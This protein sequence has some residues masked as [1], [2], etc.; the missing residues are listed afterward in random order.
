MG[1]V[2]LSELHE[3]KEDVKSLLAQTASTNTLLREHI[4]SND[5]AHTRIQT[6]IDR[7]RE[8]IRD[9]YE[10]RVID[11][12]ESSSAITAVRRDLEK[13]VDLVG[14]EVTNMKLAPGERAQQVARDVG[15]YILTL[16]IGA[17]FSALI[18]WLQSG[19]PSP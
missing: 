18:F 17:A 8:S 15:K 19:G 5:E 10:K 11:K 3:V 2:D 6:E 16:I 13:Q 4:K 7:N 1:D 14:N 9:I 12:Q